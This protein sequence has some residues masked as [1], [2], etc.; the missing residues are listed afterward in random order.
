MESMSH[1][2]PD[3]TGMIHLD[4]EDEQIWLG[5]NLLAI[6]ASMDEARQPY[7]SSDGDCGIV[8][9]GQIFNHQEL[10]AQ[11]LEDGIKVASSSDTAVLLAWIQKHGRRGLRKLVGMFAF[12][13]W[14]SE[15]RLLIIHR[16]GYGIK[17]LYIARNRQYLAVSSEPTALI[18]SGLF[19]I[20]I[21][22]RFV[23][24]YLKYKFISPHGSPWHGIKPL[25]PGEVIEY[26]EGKP[27]HFEVHFEKHAVLMESLKLAL[28]ESFKAVIPQRE[29]FGLLFSGGLDSTLILDWCLKNNLPVKPYCI[30][31]PGQQK[32][33]GAD[34][35]AAEWVGQKLG[36]QVVWVDVHQQDLI[37]MAEFIKGNQ[38]LV[39][40]SAWWLTWLIARRARKDGIRILLSGAGADEWFGGYRRHWFF[41]QWQKV[42]PFIPDRW[43]QSVLKK[44]AL[45][46]PPNQKE[47]PISQLVWEAAVSNQLS[48][49]LDPSPSLPHPV[50][51]H[52]GSPLESALAW[53]QSEY[54]PNDILTITDLAT[55]AHGIEG[56]FPFLHPNLTHFA[57]AIPAEKR[58]ENGRKHLLL[59]L[60]EPELKSYLKGRKK[61]GFGIPMTIFLQTEPGKNWINQ[62]VIKNKQAFL[63]W[64]SEESWTRF[65]HQANPEKY[66][67]E[68][69]A[70][71]WLAQWLESG[72]EK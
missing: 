47:I 62:K 64:F 28:E 45:P 49:F 29:P 40:D 58:M 68:L 31:F 41:Y 7:C 6:S 16:D 24:Y 59:Q 21:D 13:F 44:L 46:K 11:L 36:I 20:S 60:L 51:H 32:R 25:F 9:N 4:W 18:A 48:P 52:S 50:N 72:L 3:G 10:R 55:M 53:D 19:S 33:K 37:E 15:K 22:N 34:E 42:N 66:P 1:R 54:L 35:E 2:G 70:L 57:D 71:G 30:R 69:F 67:Q 27:M 14:N 43:Q 38:P 61:Q 63:P 17:P 56:R 5:H 39:A 65:L 23:S 8:F 26:W 12:V